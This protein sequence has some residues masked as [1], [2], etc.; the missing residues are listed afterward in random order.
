MPLEFFLYTGN[1]SKTADE[2]F[3]IVDS[4]GKFLPA[5]HKKAVD[6]K[7]KRSKAKDNF[8]AKGTRQGTNPNEVSKGLSYTIPDYNRSDIRFC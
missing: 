4:K 8:G 2:M 3:P 5:G 1:S 6:A 7:S